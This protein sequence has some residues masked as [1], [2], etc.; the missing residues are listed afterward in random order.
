MLEV[1]NRSSEGWLRVEDIDNFPCEDLRTIDG[2]WVDNSKGRFG[3]SVQAKIYCELG[4]TQEYNEE[5]W[6]AF[7]D[8]VG[9]RARGDSWIYYKDVTFDLK[10]PQGHLPSGRDQG[11]KFLSFGVPGYVLL[12]S[13]LASRLVEFNI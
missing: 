9:W 13:S 1:A 3:F 8:M 12:V 6:K 11:I 2:L 7:G 4:G 5:V 10:A